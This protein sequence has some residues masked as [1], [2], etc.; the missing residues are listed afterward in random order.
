MAPDFEYF[1]RMSLEGRHGHTL[2]GLFYFDLPMGLAMVFVY[3]LLV[4]RP[5]VSNLP[6]FM[7]RRLRRYSTFDWLPYFKM[8][9][10]I[11]ILSILFGAASHIF[12]DAFTHN[13]GYF[14]THIQV[15]RTPV[16]FF[17]K[18]YPIYHMLQHISTGI[19]LIIVI[20][21]LM[22]LEKEEESDPV[23]RY[24]W[25]TLIAFSILI[26]SVRIAYYNLEVKI[27]H[28]VVMAI[29]AVLFSLILSSLLVRRRYY[30][31]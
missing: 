8:N 18:D 20:T 31:S 17:G 24:W 29:A 16:F 7:N 14:A 12:W 3:H 25:I 26:F 15:L 30:S 21:V 11:V 6:A 4:K 1:L 22:K 10:F 2:P 9:W 19:G 27:G 23:Q 28:V 13:S 5:M